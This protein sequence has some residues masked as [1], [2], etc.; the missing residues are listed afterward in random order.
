MKRFDLYHL[1]LAWF[2]CSI[3]S[4]AFSA[5]PPGSQS[6]AGGADAEAGRRVLL[7]HSY[8]QEYEWTASVTRGVRQGLPAHGVDL[9]LMYMDTKRT[10]DPEAARVQGVRALRV[11]EE[12]KPEVVIAADDNAQQW[13]ARY[14]AGMERPQLVFVG[15]NGEPADYGYPAANVTGVLERPHAEASAEL[16]LQLVPSARRIAVINDRSPTAA[17]ALGHLQAGLAQRLDVVSLETPEDFPAWQSAVGRVR[18]QADAIAVFTYHTVRRRAGDTYSMPA[19]EVMAWTIAHAGM[20]V[21]GFLSYAVDDGALCG[22]VE[23]GTEQGRA[24]A[25]MAMRLLEG[26]RAED[27]P[28]ETPDGGQSMINLATARRLG[29]EPAAALVEEIDLMV[30]E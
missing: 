29:I 28:I 20:P 27:I 10:P 2:L 19:A 4:A 23:L 14:L 9:Q 5:P 13:F 18:G 25:A 15:V 12:W 24:A 11:V 3:P 8:H 26:Q 1:V 22:V 16:L 17:R 21:L 30:G 6:T 7:V